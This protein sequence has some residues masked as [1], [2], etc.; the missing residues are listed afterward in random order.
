MNT[1][2]ANDW[3]RRTNQQ[4]GRGYASIWHETPTGGYSEADPAFPDPW[5]NQQGQKSVYDAG[6]GQTANYYGSDTSGWK[7]GYA[8]TTYGPWG[9]VTGTNMVSFG[10]G[11]QT[12]YES[13]SPQQQ[14]MADAGMA[15]VR[16]A[17]QGANVV[18]DIAGGSTRSLA[19][20][21]LSKMWAP[22]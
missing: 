15:K 11:P 3:A 20:N 13:L 4:L 6:T 2:E 14:A 12:S 16:Q 1:Q 10:G 17:A 9:N 8:P 5:M 21:V 22:Q 19:P 7:E 18:S